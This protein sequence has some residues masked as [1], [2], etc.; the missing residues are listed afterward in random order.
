MLILGLLDELD[1]QE[2]EQRLLHNWL[3]MI[4]I[5]SSIS[6]KTNT[7]IP[8]VRCVERSILELRVHLVESNVELLGIYSGDTG[9]FAV[10]PL[11]VDVD[12]LRQRDV[13][14]LTVKPTT[15]E[16]YSQ[17]FILMSGRR[18]FKTN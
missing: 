13:L 3:L 9:D 4:D 5:K 1:E 8:E 16:I 6:A 2:D 18:R 7:G 15:F 11:E 17:C 14:H 10:S 12:Q